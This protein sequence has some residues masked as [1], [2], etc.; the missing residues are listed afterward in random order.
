[1]YETSD[2]RKG[3]KFQIDGVPYIV[4]GFQFVKPGKGNAFVRTKMKNMLTGAVPASQYGRAA[5]AVS[6]P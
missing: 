1:M 2:I 4:V 3:L 5:D 6:L